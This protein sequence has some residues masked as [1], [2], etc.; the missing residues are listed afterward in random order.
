MSMRIGG[1]VRHAPMRTPETLTGDDWREFPRCRDE[2]PEL[3]FPIGTGAAAQR[4]EEAAKAVCGLC[5]V[6]AQ[7]L[8]FAFES[9]SEFGVWGGMSESERRNLK[10]RPK[11]DK[12]CAACGDV[13][14]ARRAVQLSCQACE[15]ETKAAGRTQLDVFLDV[16]GDRLRQANAEGVPDTAFA[17]QWGVSKYLVGRARAVLGLAATGRTAH[18]KRAGSAVSA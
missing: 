4:Q 1:G 11:T 9:E 15:I 18:L 7:C 10:D 8:A 12:V 6:R 17:E 5:D 13:F 16:H 14:R 2:D 3:F